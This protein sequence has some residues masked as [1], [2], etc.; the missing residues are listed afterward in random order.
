MQIRQVKMLT[1]E[2]LNKRQY[3]YKIG[4]VVKFKEQFFTWTCFLGRISR[5]DIGIVIGFGDFNLCIIDVYRQGNLIEESIL[6]EKSI[7]V[8][9][10]TYNEAIMEKL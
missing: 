8:G 1:N 5:A 9:L 6:V 7:D 10:L 3:K 2:R 4:S